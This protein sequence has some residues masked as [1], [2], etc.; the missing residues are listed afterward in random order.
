MKVSYM[1]QRSVADSLSVEAGENA[2]ILGVSYMCMFVYV[3]VALGSW[4]DSVR[5]RYLLG[6]TGITIVVASLAV[7]LGILSTLGV[8]TT[9]IVWEVVPFLTLAIGVDNMF[10]I[11]REFDRLEAVPEF[12][13]TSSSSPDRDNIEKRRMFPPGNGMDGSSVF[14]RTPTRLHQRMGSAVSKVAPSILGAAV[15]EALA[16]AVGSLTDI[17]ALRQFC[18]VATAAV[19]SG[20]F[21]QVTWFVAAL[22][23][24]TRRVSQGRFDL[25]PW[26][27]KGARASSSLSRGSTSQPSSSLSDEPLT[28]PLLSPTPGNN[29]ATT[30]GINPNIGGDLGARGV[31]G[32]GWGGVGHL[33]SISGDISDGTAG[34]P[35]PGP[36]GPFQSPLLLGAGGVFSSRRGLAGETDESRRSVADGAA[37]E[38]MGSLHSTSSLTSIGVKQG[39]G[40]GKGQGKSQ[41]QGQGQG[42]GQVCELG[43]DGFP[44]VVGAPSSQGAWRTGEG[45]GSGE[46]AGLGGMGVPQRI[47]PYQDGYMVIGEEE[48]RS[49][50]MDLG[51]PGG[52]G[53]G[54]GAYRTQLY[55]EGRSNVN[56]VS[57]QASSGGRGGVVGLLVCLRGLGVRVR[58]GMGDVRRSKGCGKILAGFSFLNRGF[59]SVGPG[60]GDGLHGL[61]KFI[62]R[63]YLPVLFSRVGKIVTSLASVGLLLLG[64]LGMINLQM[65]LEPQLAAPTNFYLQ[66]YYD[67]QFS[68][69]EAGPPAYLVLTDIDYY[70]AF[71]DPQAAQELRGISTGLAQLQRYVQAPIYSWFDTMTSWV[72]QGDTLSSDCPAQIE[73]RSEADYYAMVETFLSI[74]IESQCCQSYGMCGAQFRTDVAFDGEDELGLRRIQASRLRFNMQPLASQR[75]YVNSFFYIKTITNRLADKVSERYEGQRNAWGVGNLAFPYSLY[76]VFYEQ[77]TY[78]QGVALQNIA[79]AVGVVLLSVGVLTGFQIASI[80]TALVLSTALGTVGLVWAWGELSPAPYKVSV[81]AVSVCNLVMALGLSVEFCLHISAAFKRM[82]GSRQERAAAAMKDTG[83]SVLTGI[84][85]TKLVGVSVLAVAPSRLFRLYYFRMYICLI[86]SGGFQGL[87]ALPVL[88]SWCGPHP[89]SSCSRLYPSSFS[90]ASTRRRRSQSGGRWGGNWG[91]SAPNSNMDLHPHEFHQGAES[92]SDDE[93]FF[94]SAEREAGGSRKGGAL[95][96]FFGSLND[97]EGSEKY[98][99]PPGGARI[100]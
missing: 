82:S 95:G 33:G 36:E 91:R 23:L 55:Q 30:E 67:A 98:C 47:L 25:M 32:A 99:A 5:S 88:L 66:D 37:R 38:P 93:I 14:G 28:R 31:I 72:N 80:V 51:V 34:N 75:D 7:S 74:P 46:G 3:S 18:L 12:E 17:P 11:T 81:N 92:S 50:S 69:G 59:N 83:S 45:L 13:S 79:L 84:T 16:F 60:Q 87:A 76:F 21:F 6:L 29:L 8:G 78:I 53:E 27:T 68:L 52:G 65:G 24:D 85:L 100:S 64:V 39:P 4:R 1:A 20:F 56:R 73:I 49:T 77:Y 10:L 40:S 26:K 90:A 42:Q 35:Y 71:R 48:E 94:R 19:V 57:R 89:A 97:G 54:L 58:V 62:E 15:C 22:S 43:R 44:E 63:Y 96:R 9:L 41:G 2:W 70:K 61:H 86:L